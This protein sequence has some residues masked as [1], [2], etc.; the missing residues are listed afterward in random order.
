MSKKATKAPSKAAAAKAEVQDQQ[1][2]KSFEWRGIT[3]A[4]PDELPGTVLF[5]FAEM[6]SQI[7][8]GEDRIGPTVELITSLVGADQVQAVKAKVA[9]DKLTLE[10]AL[11]EIP[12]LLNSLLEQFG[13]GLGESS[14]SQDS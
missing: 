5:D 12:G 11:E 14:A 7:R 2:P 3:L 8:A 6:E 10:E 1:E 13:M 9:E 4:L